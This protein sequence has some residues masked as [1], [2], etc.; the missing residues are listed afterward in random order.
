ML[1]KAHK[2]KI[3]RARTAHQRRVQREVVEGL[4]L[5]IWALEYEKTHQED[6]SKEHP[7]IITQLG[8]V[9]SC[10]RCYLQQDL[11]LVEAM[12][13]SSRKSVQPWLWVLVKATIHTASLSFR[14]LIA[15]QFQSKTWLCLYKVVEKSTIVCRRVIQW[16]E[17]GQNFLCSGL[18]QRLDFH[19]CQVCHTSVEQEHLGNEPHL[20]MLVRS[21]TA[22]CPC[23]TIRLQWL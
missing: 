14:V 23:K 22:S 5:L 2:V 11:T 16:H 17:A 19:L 12:S 8:N 10:H 4:G 1:T 7:T 13:T 15:A 21:S 3:E 20:L 18:E 9:F 6:A